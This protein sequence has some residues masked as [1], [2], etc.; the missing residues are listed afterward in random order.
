MK[1]LY[2]NMILVVLIALSGQGQG[3]TYFSTLS[4][5]SGG[6]YAVASDSMLATQFV[7]GTNN[8]GYV[9]QS[10]QLFLGTPS[11]NPNTFVVSLFSNRA[12]QPSVLLGLLNGDISPS[13]GI[14]DYAASGISLTASTRCYIVLTS[15]TPVS[16]GAY[17]W[18]VS[19]LFNYSASDGWTLGGGYVTS[20]NGSDW[21]SLASNPLQ[22][23]VNATAVPEPGTASLIAIALTVCG[24]YRRKA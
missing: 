12:R 15:G 9:L 21:L 3:T 24:F 17:N 19:S 7:T 6:S 20:P 22:F 5:P 8:S 18:R 14:Y 23:A 1:K 10:I 16:S 2:F 13:A 11:G 4:N